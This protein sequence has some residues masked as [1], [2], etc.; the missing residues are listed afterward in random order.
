MATAGKVPTRRVLD[1]DE[2]HRVLDAY[3]PGDCPNIPEDERLYWRRSRLILLGLV[4]GQL[5]PNQL[6]QLRWG[7]IHRT[8][9][10]IRA[11]LEALRN[12]GPDKD[13]V[14][15]VKTREVSRL[16]SQAARWGAVPGRVTP[17]TLMRSGRN[18]AC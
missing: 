6:Q 15:G 8:P 1:E 3:E 17:G 13:L 18:G 9:A 14:F 4:T 2:L 11:E 10:S 16:V 7:D 12:G 5:Q